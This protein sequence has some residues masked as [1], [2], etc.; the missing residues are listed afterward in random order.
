MQKSILM[1]GLNE[2]DIQAFATTLNLNDFYYPQLF[3]LKYTPTLTI[4][5]L[6]G[7]LGVPVAADV[8]EFDSTAPRKSRQTISKF[9][10]DIPKTEIA[11]VMTEKDLNDY[12]IMAM[13]AK[14][15]YNPAAQKQ[16]LD[17]VFDDPTFVWKGV[18]A[19]QEWLAFRALSTGIV[20]LTIA[21]NP[22]GIVTAASIDF[23]VPTANKNG[24]SI[25]WAVNSATSVPIT[26]IRAIVKKARAAGVQLNYMLMD[27]DTF[28]IMASTT[29]VKTLAAN[30]V[31]QATQTTSIPSLESVN[32]MLIANKLPQIR[33][34][35]TY[36]AIESKAGVLTTVNPWE[37][38]VVTFLPSL[39]CGNMYYSDL[40]DEMVTSSAAT[41][42]KRG[43]VLIKKFST[44]DPVSEVTKG[45]AN[46]FP[47]WATASQSYLMNTLHATTWS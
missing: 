36:V 38:G 29:Q 46:V 2:K 35:D 7:T 15:G 9:T 11:R 5:G 39:E 1:Q 47:G 37:T 25:V 27:I 28:D 42:V 24:A 19:R 18:N 43:H 32:A 8:V 21:N 20:D 41:K 44:E 4:A 23:M 45:M 33:V 10:G 16:L 26:D 40:A 30:W 14:T 31:M 12:R 34:I 3:P 13:L 17:M 22:G 6:Q